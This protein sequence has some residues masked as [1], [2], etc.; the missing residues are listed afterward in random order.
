M[1]AVLNLPEIEA[2]P[3]VRY[4]QLQDAGRAGNLHAD[5]DHTAFVPSGM[6][7]GVFDNGLEDKPRNQ[8]LIQL[9]PFHRAI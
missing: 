2:F 7:D 9:F 8:T 4:G 3:I 1:P 5:L 6:E